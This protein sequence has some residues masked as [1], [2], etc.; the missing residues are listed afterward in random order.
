MG[1][2][3]RF[4]MTRFEHLSPVE[5]V[6]CFTPESFPLSVVNAGR[7]VPMYF[8]D[9]EKMPKPV[10]DT[11]YDGWLQNQNSGK[12]ALVLRDLPYSVFPSIERNTVDIQ[13]KRMLIQSVERAASPS[14]D[15]PEVN[16]TPE[17][18]S[19]TTTPRDDNFDEL[20]CD[21]TSPP[22]NTSTEPHGIP[23]PT[24]GREDFIEL[25][26][27]PPSP[28]NGTG[29]KLFTDLWNASHT[30]TEGDNAQPEVSSSTRAEALYC[31]E[32]PGVDFGE[33]SDVEPETDCED[34]NDVPAPVIGVTSTGFRGSGAITTN[35]LPS[36]MTPVKVITS[37]EPPPV[38]LAN[39]LPALRTTR[40]RTVVQAR[41]RLPILLTLTTPTPTP[42]NKRAHPAIEEDSPTR[43]RTP[44]KPKPRPKAKFMGRAGM[45]E[46][47]STDTSLQT[48]PYNRAGEERVKRRRM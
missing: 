48:D 37:T 17:G 27:D 22:P 11:A 34:E 33:D 31:D 29:F 18:S 41:S 42:R 6:G 5:Q 26:F 44:V 24:V 13:A 45:A 46:A 23:E 8:Q 19:R 2:T 16:S 9:I 43:H 7:A 14:P 35:R 47:T 25:E 38:F 28:P 36:P 10:L 20:D 21:P 12:P 3:K 32:E 30:H 40:S 4:P 1:T 15:N 39:G